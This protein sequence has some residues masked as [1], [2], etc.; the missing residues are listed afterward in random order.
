MLKMTSLI[1]LL[2]GRR[3]RSDLLVNNILLKS[4][5]NDPFWQK[6]DQQQWKQTYYF[7]KRSYVLPLFNSDDR[8]HLRDQTSNTL[9]QKCTTEEQL[10]L[11]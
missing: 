2:M 6:K 7:N 3:I 11:M 10:H 8:A 9:G 4:H 5:N 1:Q